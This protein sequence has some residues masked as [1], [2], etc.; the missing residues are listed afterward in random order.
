MNLSTQLPLTSILSISC[1]FSLL[2]L[3]LIFSS[4]ILNPKVEAFT[5]YYAFFKNWG[6]FGSGDGQFVTPGDVVVDHSGGV[7]L[8]DHGNNR[9]Q[10]FELAEPRPAGTSEIK[11]GVCFV[12]KWGTEGSG[13]G[14]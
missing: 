9:I 10:K 11:T 7:Y 2:V 14:Q 4:V 3:I 5:G 12:I 6:T 1:T 8:I 13:N